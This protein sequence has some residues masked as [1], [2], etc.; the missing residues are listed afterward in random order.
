MKAAVLPDEGNLLEIRDVEL[1]APGPKEVVVRIAASGICHS[2][3]HVIDGHLPVPL[4]A[5]LGHEGAG[6][7]EEVGPGVTRVRPGDHVVLSWVPSCGSCFYCGIDRPDMCDEAFAIQI[8]GSLPGGGVRLR[9][10][11]EE[12][13]HFLGT[14]CFA[15]RAILHENG[16][17]KIRSDVP[18]DRAALVGCAV[19]T[20]YGA[21]MHTA[22]LPKGA[23]VAVVG[24]GGVGLNVIQ[25]AALAGARQ[26]IAL[27]RVPEKLALARRFGATDVV[28][29]SDTD[30]LVS[31]VLELTEGRGAD[32]SFEV[33][34]RPETI[35]AAYG[36]TRK[37]GTVVVVGIAAPH[38]EVSLNAF[39][40]PSQSR[41]LTGS[42][43]GRSHPDRDIPAI[44]D[45]YM[46][47]RLDLDGLITRRYDLQEINEAFAALRRGDLARGV[48]TFPQ[49]KGDA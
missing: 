11:G 27:D 45:L 37:A 20:G 29:A 47:G 42:W 8:Q 5:V 39:S 31:P 49:P 16:L 25:A 36:M 9:A 2:D 48:I 24:A 46:E 35:A 26:I 22:Q 40:I 43:Y 7:V 19:T 21:V 33:V 30:D 14:S 12:I 38:L 28:D 15:E 13:Y 10:H 18:L 32:Y 6:V 1:L 23:S 3:L 41:I 34:G 17:V 44:L 4:P